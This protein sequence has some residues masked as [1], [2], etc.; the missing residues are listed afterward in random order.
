MKNLKTIRR[1]LK[2]KRIRAKVVGTAVRPRLNVHISNRTITCQLIDDGAGKTLLAVSTL[3]QKELAGKPMTAKAEW[4]G[5]QV[6][7]LAKQA[8]I[9]TAVFD[10]GRHIYHGRV[11]ALAEAARKAGL[12]I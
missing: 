1:T 7:K 4:A 10:R 6:A 8:K 9:T 3:N 12:T 5:E 11:K 2:R